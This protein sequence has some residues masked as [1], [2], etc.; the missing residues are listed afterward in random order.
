MGLVGAGSWGTSVHAPLFAAG[1]ETVLSGIWSRTPARAAHLAAAHG[2]AAFGSFDALVAASDAIAFAVPPDVQAELAPR[3]ARAGRGVLLDKPV[4]LDVEAAQQVADAVEEAEVGSVVL[5]TYRF[6]P[7]VRRF[8][9]DVAGFDAIG[10]RACF[11]SGAFLAGTF[12]GTWREQRGALLD[13]GPHLL[14]LVE[15]ALGPIVEIRGRRSPGGWTTLAV[16]HLSGAV[17]DV[18]LCGHAAITPSRTEMEVFGPTGSLAVD[19][20]R[21]RAAGF[22]ILRAELARTVRDRGGHHLDARR[23][24]LVQELVAAAERAVAG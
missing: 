12:G 9:D 2:V 4:A 11:V 1:P 17:T 13:I 14:D 6:N 19:G 18:S 21:D 23:G 22:E 16:A 3:A 20:R 8:L 24:V 7:H 10:G 5:L 15:A